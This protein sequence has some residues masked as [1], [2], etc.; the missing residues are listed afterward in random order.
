[1]AEAAPTPVSILLVDDKRENLVALQAI[2]E[3]PEYQLFSATSGE[4]ALWLSLREDFA[5]ILLDVLMPE[6]DG[7]EV[8]RHLKDIARTEFELSLAE[9]RVAS[10]QRYRKLD[11]QGE[12][13]PDPR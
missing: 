4:E 11:A 5:V 9:M 10:D 8:A 12:A 1:M 3:S 6:M 2:L 13:A 7:F